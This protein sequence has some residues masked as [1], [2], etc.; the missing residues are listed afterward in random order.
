[1]VNNRRQSILDMLKKEKYIKTST[2]ADAFSVSQVTIRKDIAEMEAAGLVVRFHGK[3][4]LSETTTMPYIMRN[5]M[6]NAKKLA[7]AK[8]AADMV[9]NVSSITLDAG[10]TTAM[11][12]QEIFNLTPPLSVVTN[13]ISIA[14]DLTPSK[15]TVSLSGGIVL[16]HSM[17]VI[18]PDTE[19]YLKKLQTEIAFIGCTGVRDDIGLCTGLQLEGCA[20]RALMGT[21]KKVVAVFDDSKFTNTGMH[22]FANFS[23]LDAIITTHGDVP[24][25]TLE[26]LKELGVDLIYADDLYPVK[27]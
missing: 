7:I 20:K 13:S 19:E 8:V 11:I 10:T 9:R 4:M 2:L 17:C 26:R 24:P 1:M 25:V 6:N 15:H 12:A 21:G 22:M 14:S 5:E 3:I 23:D 27:K 16:S 18:G